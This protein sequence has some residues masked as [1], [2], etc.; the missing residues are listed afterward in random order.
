MRSISNIADSDVDARLRQLE[1]VIEQQQRQIGEMQ[2][3]MSG[4]QYLTQDEARRL[5]QNEMTVMVDERVEQGM[6]QMRD[7]SPIL[8]LGTNID[9]LDIRGDLRIRF[10]RRELEKTD[11]ESTEDRWRVRLRLGGVWKSEGKLQISNQFSNHYL[12]LL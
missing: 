8:T 12:C 9:G 3:A 5:I 2:S 10:E 11:D 6:A 4:Q 1:Q 7:S